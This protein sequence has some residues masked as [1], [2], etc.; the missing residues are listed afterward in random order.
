MS[1]LSASRKFRYDLDEL[2]TKLRAKEITE[3][4]FSTQRDALIAQEAKLHETLGPM[5]IVKQL[6]AIESDV[7]ANVNEK[8]QEEE[9]E[10]SERA[11]RERYAK[12]AERQRIE[13]EERQK[14]AAIE[15][16][17]KR[18]AKKREDFRSAV[19]TYI[20][21]LE[22]DTNLWQSRFNRLQIA[23]IIL[24]TATAS[25]AG[26]DG[27]PR[28]YVVIVGFA[29]AALGSILSYFQLQDKI[30]SSRKA[31]ADLQLERQMYDHCIG[32]YKNRYD[33][34]EGAYLIF[35]KKVTEIQARQ[36][37]HEVELLNP[38]K[39]DTTLEGKE[40]QKQEESSTQTSPQ[41]DQEDK[42]SP[43]T[44]EDAPPQRNRP[45]EKK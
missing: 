40:D 29:A 38:K 13:R 41:K 32:E 3:E 33:D 7:A 18:R 35:S 2:Y 1:D 42:G 22:Y 26:F 21:D 44:G 14:Q 20:S 24:T 28:L 23:L 12:T 19:D 37:L 45:E 8:F 17:N 6:E 25:M 39:K 9:R 30:Y 43:E 10:E 11:A 5:L 16:E 4:E 34:P 15:A 36:M 31:L 27:I